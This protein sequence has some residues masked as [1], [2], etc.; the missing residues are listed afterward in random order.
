MTTPTLK[1]KY[2]FLLMV[3]NWPYKFYVSGPTDIRSKGS[4]WLLSYGPQNHNDGS[5]HSGCVYAPTREK[6]IVK[7]IRLFEAQEKAAR[8]IKDAVA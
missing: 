5:A 7:A 4:E 6:V 2:D 1:D 8:L 3:A